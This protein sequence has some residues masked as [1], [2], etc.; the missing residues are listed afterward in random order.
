MS[1]KK[2]EQL[3]WTLYVLVFGG[4]LLVG[5]ALGQGVEVT[6]DGMAGDRETALEDAKRN[7]VATA[8]GQAV[9]S[10]TLVQNYALVNDRIL[11][12][13]SGYVES[14]EVVD[15][16]AW[17]NGYKVRIRA[18]VREENLLRDLDAIK[19]LSAA[20][21]NPRFVVIPDPDPAAEKFDPADPVVGQA[22]QGIRQALVDKG[23]IVIQAPGYSMNRDLT[24]PA[25]LRD[26]SEWGAGLGAEYV[27]YYSVLGL[28]EEGGRT[29]KRSTALVDL[30]IVDTGTYQMVAQ[31]EGRAVG[32]D[33]NEQIAY[34]EAGELAGK[35]AAHEA[36]ERVLAEW[37][38]TGTTAGQTLTLIVENIQGPE[39]AEF[40]DRLTVTGVVNSVD[41]KSLTDGIATFQIMLDGTK[42]DLGAAVNDVLQDL[43]W[44]GG[45]TAAGPQSL[46]YTLTAR[47][48]FG[49]EAVLDE[50]VGSEA[51]EGMEEE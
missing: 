30:S 35:N 48:G 13:A 25:G 19:V 29:F 8:V 20:R 12:S 31:V 37:S 42:A 21:G 41:M 24:S 5:S 50:P 16:G 33:R 26:L 47:G 23:V 15:E 17:A 2:I 49:D 14:Y 1:S 36:L 45:L 32:A 39:V 27:I 34:R 7:A 11:T 43:G 10:R 38:R 4:L 44:T 46:T 40:G 6:V 9:N 18:L 3:L 51:S 22:A 28:Q